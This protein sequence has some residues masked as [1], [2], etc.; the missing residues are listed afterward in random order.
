MKYLILMA[1]CPF[2]C[3]CVFTGREFAPDVIKV[4]PSMGWEMQKDVNT[5]K[6]P[7]VSVSAEWR[8]KK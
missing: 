1:L 8:I 5:K 6:K 2:M 4:T 7:S 3:G